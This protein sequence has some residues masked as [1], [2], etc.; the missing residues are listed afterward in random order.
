MLTPVRIS[1][2]NP[3][4]FLSNGAVRHYWFPD[5]IG[6]SCM[7]SNNLRFYRALLRKLRGA[8]AP[9]QAAYFRR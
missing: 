5:L 9:V 8:R 4:Y 7:F 3:P 6:V 2:V 1:V